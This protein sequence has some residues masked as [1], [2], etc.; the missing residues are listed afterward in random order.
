MN[1]DVEKLTVAYRSDASLSSLQQAGIPFARQGNG[2]TCFDPSHKGIALID[3][4]NSVY[5]PSTSGTYPVLLTVGPYGKDIHFRD[6][7]P[8]AYADFLA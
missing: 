1:V 5:R 4:T 7:N 6:F 8:K 3:G 2:I